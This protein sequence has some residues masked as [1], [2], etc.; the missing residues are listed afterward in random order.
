MDWR[1]SEGAGPGS[2]AIE[3]G[4]GKRNL[5][6]TSDQRP[7][8]DTRIRSGQSKSTDMEFDGSGSVVSSVC[9]LGGATGAGAR[10]GMRYTKPCRQEQLLDH[11]GARNPADLGPPHET[12]EAFPPP[13][14]QYCPITAAT[15]AGS[16]AYAATQLRRAGR[17]LQIASCSA[18]QK[19][20]SLQI[21]PN[22]HH[23]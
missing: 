6:P 9:G 10:R 19:A 17:G 20:P 4:Y 13:R 2:A 18:T 21:F 11:E 12:H 3:K 7:L 14:L 1:R 15:T 16:P 22:L 5:S 23:T 8:E